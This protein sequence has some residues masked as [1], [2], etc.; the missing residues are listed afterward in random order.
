MQKSFKY[1]ETDLDHYDLLPPRPAFE[2][3]G[4][5]TMGGVENMLP[6]LSPSSPSRIRAKVDTFPER[7]VDKSSLSRFGSGRPGD[8]NGELARNW[9][10]G[11]VVQ[12]AEASLECN[13]D[14]GC[15]KLRARLLI[16]A[17]GNKDTSHERLLKFQRLDFNN[18]SSDMSI[19]DSRSS[20]EEYVWESMSPTLASQNQR[21]IPASFGHN[22]I[23]ARPNAAYLQ[24]DFGSDWHNQGFLPRSDDPANSVANVISILYL[25]HDYVF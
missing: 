3:I 22:T 15:D 8:Q 23:L 14:N 1:G 6:H 24:K 17:Y 18:R 12:N 11:D 16:D 25:W 13:H 10:S 21:N 9:S 19:K 5:A 20:E 4:T 7:V 2:R